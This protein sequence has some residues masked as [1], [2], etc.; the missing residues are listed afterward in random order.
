MISQ[1]EFN[2]I[3]SD[4]SGND[5]L[6]KRV[7]LSDIQLDD[8]SIKHNHI[9]IE[10]SRVPVS[11]KFF[12]R[13]GQMVNINTGLITKMN[14]NSDKE[15]ETKLL[16]AVKSYSETRDGNKE[17]LL[18]GDSTSHQVTN[19]VKGDKYNRLSN[20][21]LFATAETILN[22]IPDMHVESIDRGGPD[23]L[24]INMIHGSQIGYEKIG[25]DEVFRFGISLI[26][27]QTVSRVDD[28]FYRLACAN[29]AVARNMDTAFQFGQGQDAFR[30]LLEQMQGWAKNGF[31]PKTFQDR[32]ERAMTT[33]A[34]YSELERALYSVTGAIQES[35]P[36][37]K[38]H[39]VKN[40]ESQF[41]PEFDA[42]TK[43]IFRK[44]FNPLQLTDAQKKFIKTDATI[45]DV[46]NELT[47]IGSHDTVF[48]LKN[49]KGFK[50]EGGNLFAKSWDLEHA[51]LA[52]I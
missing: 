8:N 46:V 42:T 7:K 16:Q 17:F 40:A 15:I 50:V 41:F 5:P 48:N 45:W 49:H 36:N 26:N 31:V 44:G 21:T 2:Q 10:G 43:R 4:L 12:N 35:D 38:A 51:G 34:S 39:L 19:I 1:S 11:D 47:W 13:L 6:V 20:D 27:G 9:E 30:K 18:I 37:F 14:K 29:G 3:K 24:S 25:K 32:L 22:E 23:G 52:T 33:K 28:F